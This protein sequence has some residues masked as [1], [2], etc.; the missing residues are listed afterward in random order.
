ME[1]VITRCRVCGSEDLKSIFD[2]GNQVM[3][4]VFPATRDMKITSGPVELVKCSG[5]GRCGLVQLKQSYDLAEMYGM[6][7]G[8]RTGLNASMAKH[9]QDKM[10][11][12][13]PSCSLHSGDLIIDIGSNDATGLK[14][15]P[16][17]IYEL[18][19]VDP[20]GVKFAEYYPSSVSLIPEFFS[21][22]VIVEKYGEKK[23]KIITS[24]SMFY[25]LEDPI[26]FAKEV[27]SI[28]DDDGVWV[29]EQSY[30]PTMLETNSFD[31]ICH[32]HL[33][34]YTL[35]QI[36]YILD[37]AEM[38]VI[39]VEFND[40]N[41]GSFSVSAVKKESSRCSNTEKIDD[42][43]DHE[44]SLGLDGLDCYKRFVGRVEAAKAELIEFLQKAKNEGKKVA[45]LGASTKG[46]VLLQY[47]GIN[48]DLLPVIGDVNPD[49]HGSFTP[50]TLIPITSEEQ[51]LNSN[52]D[53][54]LIL[55]WHF[56]K[57]FESNPKMRGRTLVFPLPRLT[58]VDV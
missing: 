18:V 41:G 50:G 31:T 23:A 24:F 14:A 55:P 42:I 5:E 26:Q 12:I 47:Y 8:Y 36:V 27:S 54:L 29:F 10:Q 56:K 39:D 44:I 37:C 21:A 46:N 20:S 15:Y 53:F 51:V 2:L 35:K 43:L 28:L 40:I 1:K 58:L 49:K 16:Q 30:L 13:F 7:Y 3:T 52:P 38:R 22:D 45:G 34:F 6:N 11:A 32:E 9:I 48:E 4:G 33:D 19:G 57:F 17:D 25:D